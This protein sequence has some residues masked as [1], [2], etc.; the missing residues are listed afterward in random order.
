MKLC[1][2]TFTYIWVSDIHEFFDFHILSTTH[3]Q[4]IELRT[5]A[6]FFLTF[7]GFCRI[8]NIKGRSTVTGKRY[9]LSIECLWPFTLL[10]TLW[11]TKNA[12]KTWFLSLSDFLF[13]KKGIQWIIK[14]SLI[15]IIDTIKLFIQQLCGGIE[16]SS[17]FKW[18]Q[19]LIFL[20]HNKT[21]SFW[22]GIFNFFEFE[23]CG[24]KRNKIKFTQ[25]CFEYV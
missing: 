23:W 10:M 16:A 14:G 1:Q 24:F 11:R 22:R 2:L 15:L 17:A 4:C 13:C 7:A 8:F 5:E 21:A 19:Q 20:L 25:L 12:L 9:V 18:M 6:Q 3:S